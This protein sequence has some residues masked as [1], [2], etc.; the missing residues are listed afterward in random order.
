MR[1]HKFLT[2]SCILA[3]HISTAWSQVTHKSATIDV[4]PQH[5]LDEYKESQLEY[6]YFGGQKV[7]LPII[8]KN[9]GKEELQLKAKMVQLSFS[10]QA[11]S[12][13]KP[14]I[15]SSMDNKSILP[16]SKLTLLELPE[17]KREVL[18]ELSFNIS[19]KEKED[20][21]QVKRVKIHVYP[22]DILEPLQAWS[23]V[24]QLRLR[25]Q[26]GVL[27]SV[28]EDNEIEFVDYKAALPKEKGP[29][30]VT[31][32]VGDPGE[33]FLENRQLHPNESIV[34]LREEIETI[35][36]VLVQPYKTATLV[37]AHLKLIN[38][39]ANDPQSQKALMEIIKLTN[40]LIE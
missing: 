16:G 11:P 21:S 32:I 26:E 1:I 34:I 6:H 18:F 20:W 23:K 12:E 15:L 35:P 29:K 37:D 38:R 39:L 22:R 33:R 8:F 19:Q 25:D 2:I 4:L 17:V 30:I 5:L 28:L 13:I 36:K 3:V 27:A 40:P 9:E 24:V 7:Y 10:L 14:E 31:I